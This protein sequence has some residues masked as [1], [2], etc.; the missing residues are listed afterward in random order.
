MRPVAV[1]AG[2]HGAAGLIQGGVAVRRVLRR[3]VFVAVHALRRLVGAAVRRAAGEAIPVAG[4]AAD[5]GLGVH[6]MGTD[7]FG[8]VLVTI[9]APLVGR[10]E[11]RGSVR[12]K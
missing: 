10:A 9:Q 3:G 6:G 1:R 4:D 2:D 7:V 12:G 8:H 5:A 11:G